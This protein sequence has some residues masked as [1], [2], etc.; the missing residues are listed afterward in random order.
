MCVC[1]RVM[2]DFALFTT[3]NIYPAHSQMPSDLF[4]THHIR[5][6]EFV[7]QGYNSVKLKQTS[8]YHQKVAVVGSHVL[9][10]GDIKLTI[11]LVPN[12]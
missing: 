6:A 10:K 7:L 8:C 4:C 1:V 5:S 12:V 3:L 11:K 9:I 2:Y